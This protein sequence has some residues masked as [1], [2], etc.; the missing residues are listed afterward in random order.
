MRTGAIRLIALFVCTCA[1]YGVRAED[2]PEALIRQGNELRKQGDGARAYGYFK[3]AYDYAHTPRTA[4]QLALVEQS[5]GRFDDAELHFSESLAGSDPWIERNR[6]TLEDSRRKVRANLGRI[7][8]QDP[9]AGSTIGVRERA[10]MAIPVDGTVWAKPGEA[11]IRISAP[12]REPV[13][14]TVSVTGGAIVRIELP[15][16]APVAKASTPV[17]TASAP[18]L[19][20]VEL[21]SASDAT[22][23]SPSP[24]VVA[25]RSSSA[26]GNTVDRGRTLR[27]AGIVA[28]SVGV[29]AGI[30]GGFVYRSGA[31]RVDSIEQTARNM[32]N[33]DPAN[34]N[35][36]TLGNAGIAM[37][38]GG[39]VA[40]AAGAVLY[41]VGRNQQGGSVDTSATHARI[42]IAPNGRLSIG[43]S[44]RF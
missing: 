6:V 36:A 13:I 15:R 30:A 27:V 12:G 16:P 5:L 44:G 42:D 3:R 29:A 35:Y 32:A 22:A 11:T 17:S 9:P 39:G 4:A 26:G 23:P 24:S 14:R 37:M 25:T 19:I 2:D 38:V 40:I 41:L 21:Q 43:L 7:E 10:A 28:A 1:P 31:I 18:A 8:I 34:G 33:Y 20:P